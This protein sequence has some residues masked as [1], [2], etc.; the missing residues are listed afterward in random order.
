V[1]TTQLADA[2]VPQ[3]F[4]RYMF[5]DTTERSRIFR[6]GIMRSD[7]SLASFLSGGGL[8][9]NIPFWKDL[10]DSQP[11]IANDD[12]ASVITPAK[13]GTGNMV[14]IRQIRTKAWSSADLVQEL[15]GSDPMARIRERVSDYWTRA[16]ER[17]LTSTLI[18]VFA[19]NAANDA[20]DMRLVVGTD[21]TGAPAATELMSADNILEGAQTMGDF[22]ERL[23]ALIVHS[24]IYANLQKLNL[25]DFIPNA[26]GEVGFPTYLGYTLIVSDQVPIVQGTNRKKY[27]SYLVGEGAI[28]WSESP[29]AIPTEVRREPL[30]GNG[31]G[32]EIL[33]TRRQYIMHPIGMKWTDASRAGNFPT[34][35]EIQAAANWDRQAAER[36][37]IPLVEIVT[38]G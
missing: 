32:V 19:D 29:V 11:G 2:V 28:D 6:S 31:M 13:I 5:M 4:N 23:G 15:A 8:T 21:A 12:P 33:V 16:F 9:V 37:M 25:I 38:N 36:K 26:R 34:D 27:S 1:A 20:G 18:G 7:P 10:D 35:A 17:N 24:R 30:Q 22:Q 14:A 3:V